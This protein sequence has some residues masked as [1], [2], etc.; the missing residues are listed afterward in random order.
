MPVQNFF[1]YMREKSNMAIHFETIREIINKL[2]T[3]ANQ[4]D[5]TKPNTIFQPKEKP[6]VAERM[7]K[8]FDVA[9]GK[10]PEWN[11]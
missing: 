2:D 7:N 6:S 9:D 5:M 8:F 4:V 1:L 3:L 11:V 10:N